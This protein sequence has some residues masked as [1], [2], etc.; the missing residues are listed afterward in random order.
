MKKLA[1]SA[2]TV[3]LISGCA[4]F[5][6]SASHLRS[7][8]PRFTTF[9]TISPQ[10]MA[11][12]IDNGWVASGHSRLTT[13]Q[14]DTGYTL[15]SNQKLVLDH[16]KVPMYFVDVNT[17]REGASVRFYTNRADEIADRSMISIIQRCD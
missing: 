17:S 9:S 7:T 12:C 6:M 3:L 10:A 5:D 2:A 4:S 16:E 1:L 14:T 8:V 15:Q 13:T 11:T